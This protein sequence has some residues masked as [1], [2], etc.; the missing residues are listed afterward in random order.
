MLPVAI[1][2]AGG[3]FRAPMGIAV[4]GGLITSTALTLLIVPAVFSLIDDLEKWTSPRV[5]KWLT[6]SSERDAPAPR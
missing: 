6:T 1:S 5:A 3:G 4:I 2:T